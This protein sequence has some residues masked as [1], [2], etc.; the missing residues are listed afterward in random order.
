MTSHKATFDTYKVI[1]SQNVCLDD[2]NMAE[3]ISMGS[4]VVGVETK[5][6]M[7]KIRITDVLHVPKLQANLLLISKFF[8]NVLNVQFHVNECIVGG[9]NGDVVAIA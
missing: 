4:I 7:T 3:T 1:S 9:V 8:L 6:K 2:D 5:C